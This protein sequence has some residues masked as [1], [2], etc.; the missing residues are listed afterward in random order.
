MRASVLVFCILCVVPFLA[1][2][3]SDNSINFKGL[4]RPEV[5]SNADN[6]LCG[7]CVQLMGQTIKYVFF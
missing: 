4:N 7:V 3:I 5:K 1:L 2:A 6:A